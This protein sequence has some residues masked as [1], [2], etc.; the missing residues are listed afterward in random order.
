MADYSETVSVGP[1]PLSERNPDEYQP[2]RL[3]ADRYEIRERLRRGGQAT[4]YRAFDRSLGI[5]VALKFIHRQAE[6]AFSR[7][8][9]EVGRVRDI[10]CPSLVHIYDIG[11]APDGHFLTMEFLSGG[12]LQDRLREG[13]LPVEDATRIAAAVLEGLQALH[14]KGAIHRDVT[15]GNILFSKAGEAKLADFGLVRNFRGEE[16]PLT[17]EA[18][19]LGTP[20][21][22]SPEQLGRGKAGPPSDLYA[23]GV[24]L[25]EMLCGRRPESRAEATDVR[26][27]RAGVPLWLSEVA[28]RLLEENP[29]DR[30]PDA[31]AALL[32]LGSES[33]PPRY[34]LR[35]R[36]LKGGAASLLLFSLFLAW[37]L[38]A[39]TR[40]AEAYSHL[41]AAGETGITAIGK[42]GKRLWTIPDV[43]P[44]VADRAALARITPGGPRLL[45]LVLTRP[46]EW[47]QEAVSRLTFLDPATGKIVREVPLPHGADHFPNDPPRFSFASARSVD[48]TN[49][50]VDEVLVN[51]NHIPEAPFYSVL[52]APRYDQTR[53]VYYSRGGQDFRGAADLDGDG[54]KELIFVG[55]DNGWNW[56]NVMAAVSFDP[57]SLRTGNW[58]VTPG[59]PNATGQPAQT[60]SLLW[61]A[62]LPR[63]YFQDPDCLTIDETGRRLTVRYRSGK[64]WTLGYDGFP[65]TDPPFDKAARQ[66]ARRE[67]YVHLVESERLRRAGTHDLAMAEARAA[68]D[69]AGRAREAWLGEYAKRLQAKILVA[70]GR[71]QEAEDRFKSLAERA[72]DAPEVSYDA[73]VAFHLAGDLR[74]AVAWYREGLGRMSAMGAGKSK[75]EFL[76]GEVLALVEG[77]RYEEALKAVSRFAAIYSW[78]KWNYRE[79]IRWRAGERPEPDPEGVTVNSTDL[80]RYWVLEFAFASGEAPGKLLAQVDR[81]LEERPETRAEVLSLRAEL[82]A[83]LGRRSEA[84]ET[85]ARAL[86]A[87]QAEAA[88]SIVARGHLGL[89]EERF[90]RL[91]GRP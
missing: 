61:Y 7:L 47:S 42:N 18:A 83:R 63:G 54:A 88:S 81:Y 16:D 44:E 20:G 5:E 90:R 24:V 49:D 26:T 39:K 14:E 33:R 45:A 69:A 59:A 56:V 3:V 51:F 37:H 82:L 32:A 31:R 67:T 2:G 66:T 6:N 78:H 53:I 86:E 50:G 41:V 34:R 62:I 19:V 12:S 15:P 30:F 57:R 38:I 25:F 64:T 40:R 85:A 52:Y 58:I 55:I 84:A 46:G 71:L 73:A 74:Q 87:V 8:R 23:T 10:Q 11:S 79:Y 72:D 68:E 36:I 4:V 27:V 22:L 21:Y 75:H 9:R 13:P 29:A 60:P 1:L 65:P 43:K 48:L 17:R 89:V 77:R 35:R 28:S 80:D 76:K 91:G 70:E